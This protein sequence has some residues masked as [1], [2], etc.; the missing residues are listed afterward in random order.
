M[1]GAMKELVVISM[2]L[3]LSYGFNL[4]IL[5][6]NDVHARFEQFDKYGGRCSE[7]EAEAG[8]CFGGVAR[9]YT[10]IEEIRKAEP[11]VILL[12][13]G[14][15]AQGTLWFS[16]FKGKATAHFMNELGYDVM[17]LG[18]HEFDNGL[19]GLAQFLEN[20]TFPVVSSNINAANV[21]EMR[22][23]FNKSTVLT[24]AGEK[25]GV[26]GY[27]TTDTP[28]I[29]SPGALIFTEEVAAVQAEADKLTSQGIDKIIALG[30][31]GFPVDK[32][33]AEFVTGV[34][35]VVS[36]HT[37]TFLYTGTPPSTEVPE[38]EYPVVM[39]QS[40]GRKVLIVSDFWLGKY[41]GHLAVTFDDAGE[42]TSWNGNPILLDKTVPEDNATLTKLQP[43]KQRV[44]EFGSR[45][46]GSSL[47]LLNDTGCKFYECSL[48]NLMADA[49]VDKYLKPS[50]G[51]RWTNRSIGIWNS[52]SFRAPLRV[53]DILVSD[54]RGAVPFG[55]GADIAQIS[56]S[57]LWA[58]LEHSVS[59][60]EEKVGRFLQVSGL[61]VVYDISK[62]VG[63][64]VVSVD[65][66]C[67]DCIVP[68]FQPLIKT[69]IYEVITSSFILGGG[70][71]YSVLR[72]NIVY[73]Y[74]IDTLDADVLMDYIK[75]Y[76]PVYHGVEDRIKFVTGS[77]QP[78]STNQAYAAVPTFTL[79]LFALFF[80][81][82]C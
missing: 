76:S 58:V 62:P 45:Q 16:M 9:R 40:G 10:K 33:V 18:N 50:D 1:A 27:T 17:T 36:G 65:V 6:T 39:T 15:Q 72:D 19:D 82:N 49:L 32:K 47:V 29:S 78:C 44:T 59:K 81:G 67:A 41:L 69:K 56:G 43:W 48:G 57:T 3:T 71:D 23:L 30:H 75:K 2:C 66:R 64:R 77:V 60:Y 55:N 25:I 4:T 7:T 13:A 14:D 42:V 21:P 63:S 61:R 35:I 80:M 53:G 73:R 34:D 68:K 54:V 31:S 5:H 8:E 22:G 74:G 51:S 11:D 28:T 26:I 52:G 24:V 12:D 79:I 70:D 20:V 46:I 37:N 38:G